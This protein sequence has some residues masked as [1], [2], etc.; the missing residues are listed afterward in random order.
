[1]R[2]NHHL[3]SH[4]TRMEKKSL[5]ETKHAGPSVGDPGGAGVHLIVSAITAV[6]GSANWV[7]RLILFDAA[8]VLVVCHVADPPTQSDSR[9]CLCLCFVTN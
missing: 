9:K 6:Y 7:P 2:T 5:S 8:M 4:I 3:D 1:M